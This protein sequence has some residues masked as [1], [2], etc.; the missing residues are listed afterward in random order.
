MIKA[1]AVV[2]AVLTF[3]AGAALADAGGG[4]VYIG[5]S[6]GYTE[7][8]D[9]DEDSIGPGPFTRSDVDDSSDGTEI[10]L[11]LRFGSGIP[12]LSHFAI[13]AGY[14][15][16]GNFSID[17]NTAPGDAGA[18]TDLDAAGFLG[19]L[20]GGL[21]GGLIGGGGDPGSFAPD[22][23]RAEV[24]VEG[25]QYGLVGFIPIT[26]RLQVFGRGGIFDWKVESSLVATDRSGTG[27]TVR[28]K[29]KTKGDDPFFGGGISWTADKHWSVR[30]EWRR[31]QIDDDDLDF[32]SAGGAFHF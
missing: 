4:G 32:I 18:L 21:L 13:E 25:W 27:M 10:F 24:D 29:E 2:G 31:L 1:S 17:A 15:N 28:A 30:A 16:L 9:F 5:G 19:D 11:G 14:M 7:L 22:N 12:I 20:I 23:Y 6:V 8:N 3:A 26:E